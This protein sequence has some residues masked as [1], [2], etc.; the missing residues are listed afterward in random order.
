MSK[1]LTPADLAQFHGSETWYRHALVRTV[2]YT[3]GVKF[4][5]DAAGAHWLVDKIAT[6][7]LEPRV[8]KEEFQ[9]WKLT[10]VGDGPQAVLTCD[11]G[12]DNV[13]H[14]EPIDY[15]DFPFE[16]GVDP[17]R[18]YFAGGVIMLPSEY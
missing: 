15:T 9:H 1:I 8:G 2:C 13:I 11:D 14:S 3:D 18:L 16:G 17:A 10:H 4:L 6:L 12:N 7:Q 5:A